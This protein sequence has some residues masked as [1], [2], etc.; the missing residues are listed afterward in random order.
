MPDADGD[1][2]VDGKDLTVFAADFNGDEDLLLAFAQAFGL[3]PFKE[4]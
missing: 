3:E 2:D 4:P 1:Q